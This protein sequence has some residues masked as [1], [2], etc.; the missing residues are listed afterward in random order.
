M[1]NLPKKNYTQVCK[2]E[3]CSEHGI[4][5]TTLDKLMAEH[6]NPP[7][8]VLVQ[9]TRGKPAVAYDYIEMTRFLAQIRHKYRDKPALQEEGWKPGAH[10]MSES[11]QC[12]RAKVFYQQ[13]SAAGR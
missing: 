10:E 4:R 7:K 11:W 5:I 2:Y 13:L 8:A 12:K 6:S 3:I 1:K 9:G